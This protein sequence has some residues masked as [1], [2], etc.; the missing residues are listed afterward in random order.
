M[1]TDALQ[2]PLRLRLAPAT[3]EALFHAGIA[4]L[5]V[6]LSVSSFAV[7]TVFGVAASF[8]M[9]AIVAL[10]LPASIPLVI[11]VSFVIQNVVVAWY[12]PLITDN[13]DF[14]ALRGA[15]F[16]VL[17]T[18]F[19]AFFVAA[20]QARARAIPELRPWIVGGVWLCAV[21]VVYLGLGAI[22]GDAKDAIVYFRN[23]ITPIA[24]FYVAIVAASLYRVDLQ[25]VIPWLAGF[26]IAY[27][28][29][30]LAFG[31]DFLSLFHGDD[32]ITRTIWRQIQSGAY[33]K[34]LQET[35]F[36]LRGLQDVLLTNL[37]NLPIPGLPQ[38]FR[39]GGPTFHSIS[40][41]YAL[42]VVSVWLLFN[43]R[44]LLPLLALPLLLVIGS[45][46]AMFLLLV[47]LF[48]RLASPLLGVRPALL[49][50]V[51]AS[52]LWVVGSI[53]FG[54]RAGD[55]HVLGLFAGLREFLHN[56]LGIGLGF[57]GN[58][59]STTIDVNWDLAQAHGAA[60]QPME[61]AI[62]V[63]LYQ[64]GV[65][66]LVFLAFLLA[67]ARAAWRAFRR[68]GDFA[69]LFLIVAVIAIAANAV[70]QEEAFFS[71]LALGLALLL[72]GAGLP[73]HWSRPAS[74]EAGNR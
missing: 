73:S 55:Y 20:F 74:A 37:F 68:S 39:I 59:S 6:I 44:W 15:N 42:S 5:I 62:G 70:L 14:D 19:A 26:A 36:V 56:P 34:A 31:M 16:V 8:A 10:V 69:V 43:K 48:V 32:Y 35:G 47:G 4:I 54:V 67:I 17:A 53:G 22:H 45:K 58:L 21:V 1:T 2:P 71:P 49:L 18:A 12:T 38:V 65:G 3:T 27:G 29:C 25:R 50:T 64:M 24:T 7:S 41:A 60:A 52:M 30:E 61:S 9:T 72:G 28:Y 46:G 57:G 40:F 51:A 11:A 33:E 63:M 66:S 13:T 23:V